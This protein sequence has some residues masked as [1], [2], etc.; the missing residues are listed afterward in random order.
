MEESRNRR[1]EI[2]HPLISWSCPLLSN[3]CAGQACGCISCAFM[4]VDTVRGW[5]CVCV[6]EESRPKG[7]RKGARLFPHSLGGPRGI[8]A[9]GVC[10]LI[11]ARIAGT[12]AQ[13][14][15]GQIQ[16]LEMII[17][18]N[19]EVQGIAAARVF[20]AAVAHLVRGGILRV[21]HLHTHTQT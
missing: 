3:V 17:N 16:I 19:W 5:T 13:S 7:D 20:P 8:T 14:R 10:V 11:S 6:C 15:D 9:R 4:C 21:P 1:C 2:F 12:L 18:R